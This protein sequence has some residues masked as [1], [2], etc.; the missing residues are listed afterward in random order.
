[1]RTLPGLLIT[2]LSGYAYPTPASPWFL[3]KNN[4][5]CF[6]PG[7]VISVRILVIK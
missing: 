6:R 1:M 2:E 5:Y 7:H 3:I 4:I